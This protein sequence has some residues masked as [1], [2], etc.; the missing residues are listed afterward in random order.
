MFR[1][2]KNG[3][4]LS[5]KIAQNMLQRIV[6]EEFPPGTLLPSERELQDDYQVSR[7]VVREAIKLLSSRKLVTTSRG[8]GAVVTS[9]FTEPVVD[10]LLLAFHRSQIHAEDIFSIRKLLEPEAAALAAHNATIQQIRG[11]T[12]ITNRFEEISFESDISDYKDALNRW[13]KLDHE[14]HQ[15]LA[16]SSQNTVLSILV[17]VIVGIVWNAISNKMPQPTPDRFVVSVKQHKAIARA[18]AEHD[19]DAARTAMIEHIEASLR[20]VVSPEKRVEI[21]IDDLI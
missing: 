1:L 10:A 7:A 15:L 5:T 12:E 19:A 3:D 6:S 17:G 16:E 8:Q 13:G 4:T 14:F 18:I 21:E 20:N 2:T 9:N 11:L